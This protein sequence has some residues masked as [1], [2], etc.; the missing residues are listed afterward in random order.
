MIP[1]SLSLKGFLSYRDHTEV[2]FSQVTTACIS[3]PNGAGK[4]SLFDAITWS[5]FGRARRNDDALINDA[6]QSCFVSFEFLYENDRY[7]VQ[8]E[9]GRGSGTIL[10]FQ[11]QTPQGSWKPLTEA[12]LRS[13]EERI[14][15]VLRLDYDTFINASFFLQGKADMFTQQPPG[16]RKEILSSVLGLE[17][18][19]S[20]REE[21]ARR[22]REAEGKVQSLRAFLEEILAELAEEDERLER[23]K[24]LKENLIKTSALRQ[25]KEQSWERIREKIEERNLLEE[26]RNLLF[27]QLERFRSRFNETSTSLESLNKELEIKQSVLENEDQIRK[28][29]SRWKEL[30]GAL[31]RWNK[32][33]DA[34]HRLMGRYAALEANVQAEAARLNQELAG[35][36]NLEKEM[37]TLKKELPSIEKE[38]KKESEKLASLEASTA[39]LPEMEENLNEMQKQKAELQAQ[40]NQLRE[41][42]KEI[43]DRISRL[44]TTEDTECPLCGQD[45]SD[46]RRKEMMANLNK[47]GNEMGMRFREKKETIIEIENQIKESKKRILEIRNQRAALSVKQ[48]SIGR[49]SQQAEDFRK[50]LQSWRKEG[51]VRLK[52]VSRQLETEEYASENRLEMEELQTSIHALGYDEK[53][54]EKIRREE[55]AAREAEWK[56]LLLENAR[57]AVESLRRETASLSASQNELTN[58]IKDHER[59]L[60]ET[61]EKI[62]AIKE[63]IQDAEIIRK[64]LDQLIDEENH[65][66]QEVGGAQQMVDVLAYQK[67]KREEYQSQIDDQNRLI[68]QLNTLETAFGK[69][70]VPALLIE[71]ALPDIEYQANDILDRLSGGRMS[72]SFETE[73]AYKDKNREDKKQTLDILISDASGQRKYELFSGGEAFRINF[74]VRLAL[75][76][77]LAGRAGARLQTLVVDEGFGSQDAEGR[78]RLIEAINMV[79]RDFEKILVITHLEDLKDAF[80]SRIEVRKES[81]TSLVEVIP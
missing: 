17:I 41:K 48:S 49:L 73:R 72:V 53:E 13:T 1:I 68:A 26:R 54:H 32:T 2:D 61:E 35:L 74:A 64:E 76:R 77:V 29:Y 37:E 21:A 47:E 66:R 28:D 11:I 52:T 67:E 24:L 59:N 8:R 50:R 46:A 33:A 71:Q 78:Q 18:W 27:D 3:G 10:E 34:Y 43:K 39:Q 25:E 9:K 22:R 7:R 16:K 12:G 55:S 31:E 70:G 5:L 38:L 63:K 40:N 4:S 60:E 81:G 65:L 80:P 56:F 36:Q 23:L 62:S 45:L 14:R 79:S 42:M 51:K 58:E 30:R 75:S 19:E 44:E 15:E 6:S 57:S 20:Y 69:N